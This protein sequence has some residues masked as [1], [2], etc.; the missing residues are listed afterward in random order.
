MN[1]LVRNFLQVFTFFHLFQQV[2]IIRFIEAEIP[3]TIFYSTAECINEINSYC[4][5]LLRGDT[6]LPIPS[7]LH[8]LP[9][10]L[11]ENN[12]RWATYVLASGY[13]ILEIM[14]FVFCC[15]GIIS[16][17]FLQKINV[18]SVNHLSPSIISQSLQHMF[19]KRCTNYVIYLY[20]LF[21]LSYKLPK[22]LYKVLAKIQHVF[23]KTSAMVLAMLPSNLTTLPT[24]LFF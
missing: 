22:S 1:L 4:I 19:R 17:L 10:L 6:G 5:G 15:F 13:I 20:R 21:Y 8:S 7:I 12:H 24:I 16:I 2:C 14:L 11:S 23:H 9:I 3:V 18:I